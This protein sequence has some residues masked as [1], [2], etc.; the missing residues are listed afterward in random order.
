MHSEILTI[1]PNEASKYLANNPANRKISEKEVEALASDM[2]EGRWHITHQGIAI[3]KTGRLLDGQHRLAA[4]IKAGIPVQMMVTFDVDESAMDA[5]DQGRRRSVGDI[6]L[7]AGEEPWMRSKTV[8]AAA[9]F[10]LCYRSNLAAS[11]DEIRTLL[12]RYPMQFSLC[13]KLF[14]SSSRGARNMHASITAA[15]VAAGI[16]G[17]PEPELTAFFDLYAND[18]LPG[19]GYNSEIVLKFKNYM[20]QNKLRHTSPNKVEL[21]KLASNVIYNFVRN[22]K[23][24]LL[25]T[26]DTE[27]YTVDV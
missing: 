5:I 6:F 3:G 22:T 12:N 9:R 21:Y 17:V 1:T 15:I 11:A 27:R 23:T 26:P 25:R 24:T 20:V 16:N 13:Y 7:F 19:S 4:V 14:N 2:R 18:R 8:I 10:L